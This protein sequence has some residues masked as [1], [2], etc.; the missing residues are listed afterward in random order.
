MAAGCGAGCGS[1]IG[2]LGLRLLR[3]S[4]RKFGLGLLGLGR[5]IAVFDEVLDGPRVKVLFVSSHSLN[6]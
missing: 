3:G 1:G 6:K 5:G 2:F 4:R